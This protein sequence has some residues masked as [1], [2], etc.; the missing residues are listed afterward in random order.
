MVYAEEQRV[1]PQERSRPHRHARNEMLKVL[2]ALQQDQGP[3]A[4]I[5]FEELCKRAGI[6]EDVFHVN[7]TVL[8]GLGLI[9]SRSAGHFRITPEGLRRVN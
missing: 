3:K 4:T 6:D 9:E 1:V 2:A 5:Y 8:R 7:E